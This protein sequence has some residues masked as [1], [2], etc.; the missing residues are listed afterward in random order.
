M[1]DVH[2]KAFVAESQKDNLF[3]KKMELNGKN[4]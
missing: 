3:H 1:V 4:K 2:F